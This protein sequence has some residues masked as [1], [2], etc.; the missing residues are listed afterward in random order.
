[1]QGKFTWRNHGELLDRLFG[2]LPQLIDR[3]IEWGLKSDPY[4]AVTLVCSGP[5]PF[6]GATSYLVQIGH[7]FFFRFLVLSFPCVHVWYVREE[8]D[9]PGQISKRCRAYDGPFKRFGPKTT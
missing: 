1:M 3:L 5:D 8:V 7:S 9:N 6:K 4:N 2:Y